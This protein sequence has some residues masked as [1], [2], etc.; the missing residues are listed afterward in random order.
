MSLTD[1]TS[2]LPKRYH[3]VVVTLHWL[4][5]ILILITALLVMGGDDERG[6]F[7][8]GSQPGSAQPGS[9]PSQTVPPPG[10]AGRPLQPSSIFSSIGLH[11]ILGAS[12]IVLLLIRLIARW[13]TQ[14][15]EWASTGNAFL[16]MIGGWT[17]FGLYLLGF[18]MPITGIILA[19]QRNELAR[20]F[21]I[22]AVAARNTFRRGQFSLGMFHGLVWTLLLLL[23]ALHVGAAFYHQ[24]FKKDNLLARMWYGK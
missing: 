14:H 11:M 21:G 1:S 9:V 15:P 4:V 17:H 13:R 12:I 23:I 19:V 20:V 10:D 16:D 6:R 8:P 2:T 3:P 18:L 24:F 22:G 5:A 7:R